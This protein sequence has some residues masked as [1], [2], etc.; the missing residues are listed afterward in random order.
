[1]DSEIRRPSPWLAAAVAAKG[2]A[3]RRLQTMA[4]RRALAAPT[5][6]RTQPA[7]EEW[8]PFALAATRPPADTACSLRLLHEVAVV[9]R[10]A[11][12]ELRYRVASSIV[13]RQIAHLLA[14]RALRPRGLASCS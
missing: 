11:S 1:M 14:A 4:E 9:D 6:A 5:Q 3:L 7:V 8:V 10:R 13:E 12:R 2:R